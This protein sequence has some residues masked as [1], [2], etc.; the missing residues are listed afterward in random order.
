M[1][2]LKSFCQSSDEPNKQC[3]ISS[4]SAVDSP[5]S[6]FSGYT[7]HERHLSKNVLI[8][9]L[10]AHFLHYFLYLSAFRAPLFDVCVSGCVFVGKHYCVIGCVCE[11]ADCPLSRWNEWPHHCTHLF[12][13]F[14]FDCPCFDEGKRMNVREDDNYEGEV[15]IW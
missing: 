10:F 8:R 11:C 7:E 1:N 9:L 2:R 4:T 12:L 14:Y 15:T 6:F 3:C 13:F 5:Y